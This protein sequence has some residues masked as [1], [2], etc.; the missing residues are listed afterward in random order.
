MHPFKSGRQDADASISM[1]T[2]YAS[3]SFEPFLYFSMKVTSRA[4]DKFFNFLSSITAS[5]GNF[6]FINLKPIVNL[7]ISL[8]LFFIQ[9]LNQISLW[10]YLFLLLTFLKNY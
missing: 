8:F 7:N 1:M 3:S 9:D 6:T 2:S 10:K 5:R 4:F